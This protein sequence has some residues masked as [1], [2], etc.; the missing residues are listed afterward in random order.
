MCDSPCRRGHHPERAVGEFLQRGVP[1]DSPAIDHQRR[2]ACPFLQSGNVQIVVLRPVRQHHHH[3]GSR[4][5][6][7]WIFTVDPS[8]LERLADASQCLGVVHADHVA[9]LEELRR[10]HHRLRLFDDVRA[11]LVRKAQQRHGRSGQGVLADHREQPVDHFAVDLHHARTEVGVGPGVLGTTLKRQVVARKTRTAESQPA[12]EVPTAHARV[13]P[14]RCGHHVDVRARN[15]LADQRQLVGEADLHGHVAVE[16]Q[17]GDLRVGQVHDR[18]VRIVLHHGR[19]QLPAQLRR[20]LVG[21]AD[22]QHVRMEEVVNHRPQRD[23][24]GIVDEPEVPPAYLARQLLQ[25]GHKDVFTRRRHDRGNQGHNVERLL[26]LQAPGDAIENRFDV[27]VGEAAVRVARGRHRNQG[28][29]A[30]LHGI[31]VA[32]GE[33][34]ARSAPVQQ[35]RQSG[36]VD[37]T[38]SADK[39]FHVLGAGIHANDVMSLAGEARRRAKAQFS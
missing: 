18:I 1:I 26:G 8:S 23:E 12:L 15:P 2:R 34:H 38:P 39:C 33:L 19:V 30:V 35:R 6:V 17:L 32:R 25:D 22:E 24:L 27:R 36:L 37:R 31:P 9:S 4:D 13:G 3:A 20:P 16:A 11:W 7:V 14:D 29:V 10:E 21:G 28:N 5:G